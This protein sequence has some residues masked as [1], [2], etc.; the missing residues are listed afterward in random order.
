MEAG[1]SCHLNTFTS[2][3]TLAIQSQPDQS[4]HQTTLSKKLR[5]NHTSICTNP[6]ISTLLDEFRYG[7]HCLGQQ[8]DFQRSFLT[9]PHQICQHTN[10]DTCGSLT[11]LTYQIRSGY[12]FGAHFL[13]LQPHEALSRIVK[14]KDPITSPFSRL[15]VIFV[16]RCRF[17]LYHVPLAEL[18][19]LP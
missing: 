6:K 13:R 19:Y 7:I 18:H 10:P 9:S 16:S 4:D 2:S 17:A 11:Y 5:C 1:L 15:L 3:K 8:T 14:I 12:R